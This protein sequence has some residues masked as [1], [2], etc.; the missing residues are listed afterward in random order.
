M[1]CGKAGVMAVSGHQWSL[2]PG[3]NDPF[4]CAE[5]DPVPAEFVARQHGQQWIRGVT[6]LCRTKGAGHVNGPD[7]RC[8]DVAVTDETVKSARRFG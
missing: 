1:R 6:T 2:G 7:R 3:P 4:P 5:R 8:L